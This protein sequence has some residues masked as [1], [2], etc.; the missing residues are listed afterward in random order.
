MDE[1]AEDPLFR[2]REMLVD[3][4]GA[5]DAPLPTLGVAVKLDGTPGSVRTPPPAFGADT[6]AV[7]REL[8]YP[9][10]RIDEF[11]KEGIV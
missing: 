8:G 4:K 1:L 10:G 6:R 3:L 9:E 7:L 11:H 5:D 2:R